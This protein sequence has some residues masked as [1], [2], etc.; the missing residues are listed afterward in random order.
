LRGL[1]LG[2]GLES[3]PSPWRA[4]VRRDS[5]LPFDGGGPR[6]RCWQAV[7]RGPATS[8]RASL[9]VAKSGDTL[10]RHRP[11][12]PWLRRDELAILVEGHRHAVALVTDRIKGPPQHFPRRFPAAILAHGLDL[13]RCR[14]WRAIPVLVARPRQ[15]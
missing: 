2:E 4:G 14:L 5:N 7:A 6:A 3:R 10:L 15:D 1:L 8:P 12:E 11:A 9:P 13:L